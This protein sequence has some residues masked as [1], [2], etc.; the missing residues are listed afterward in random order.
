MEELTH[1][2]EIVKM[3]IDFGVQYSFQILGALIILGIGIYVAGWLSRL[4][5]RLCEKK[6]MDV[7]LTIFLGRIVK[8]VVMTFVIIMAMGKFGF[9]I[10][11]LIAALGAM[12]FGASFAL[13]GPISNYSAGMIII[14]TRPFVV[15]DTILIEGV[16][17]VVEEVTL[18]TTILSTEDGERITI[19][20]KHIVG[21]ILTNSFE[22]K[23]VEG[24]IGISYDDDPEK[25][26]EIIREIIAS[27]DSI[28]KEPSPQIGIEEYA[29]S[30]INIGMRYWVPTKAYYQ[31]L[32]AVNLAVYKKIKEAGITI[33]FPQRDVHM[34]SN[35]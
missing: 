30:S 14:I 17:G 20:N 26:I 8:L 24:V 33:P 13:Q 25:A 12:A 15:G 35:S 18:A 34:V 5:M 32:Y 31:T 28:P 16:H 10:A 3:I 23:V 2:Q 6:E 9:S 19:P 11:P 29:D 21:E 7:T 1:M 22:N 27:S 4:V